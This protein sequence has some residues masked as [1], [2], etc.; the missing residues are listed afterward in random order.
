MMRPH[1]ILLP[2]LLCDYRLWAHQIEHLAGVADITVPDMTGSDRLSGLARTV[3]NQSPGTFLLAGLSMGGYVAQEIMR[4][5]PDRVTKLALL[6]TS[7]LA[8][9]AEVTERRQ[10]MIR[11]A[12]T[13][14][15]SKIMPMML[16]QLLHTDSLANEMLTGTVKAMASTIGPEAF[17]RQQKV[18]MQ[19]PDSR[20]SLK[21]ITCP[22]LVLCGEADALT[23]PAVH[24]EMQG[25]IPGSTLI[26]VEGAGHLS[27]LEAPVRVTEALKDWIEA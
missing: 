4:Q 2:G 7:P 20:E 10:G 14:N 9:T 24:E 8:D 3:L 6:D 1:L 23:P 25:L 5:A 18:I 13:G 19:R 22:T 27:P 16:P 17:I 12:E 15:F 26:M 11:L 21:S